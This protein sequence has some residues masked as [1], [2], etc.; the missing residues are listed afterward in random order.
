VHKLPTLA[1]VFLSPFLLSQRRLALALG[2]AM[3]LPLAAAPDGDGGNNWEVT[4][5]AEDT[6]LK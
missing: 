3:V 1:A 5:I 6:R 2:M 4:W